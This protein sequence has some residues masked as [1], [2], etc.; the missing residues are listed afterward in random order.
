MLRRLIRRLRHSR[1]NRPDKPFQAASMEGSARRVEPLRLSDWTPKD[2]ELY[3]DWTP[4]FHPEILAWLSDEQLRLEPNVVGEDLYEIEI[5]SEQGCQRLLREV[6]AFEAW[7]GQYQVDVTQPNS[8][9]QYGV[10]LQHIQMD[11]AAQG[12]IEVL[13]PIWAKC[14]P[15]VGSGHLDGLHAF[16]VS[17]APFGGDR[18]LGFHV[19]NSEVTLNITLECAEEGSEIYFQGRRC[20]QHRQ[21]PHR[22]EEEIVLT[23]KRGSMLI[24]AGAH[25]HGVLPI[26]SGQRKSL[27][28]WLTSSEYR[29]KQQGACEPWC[30]DY[31]LG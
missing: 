11:K 10:I 4:L 24:H 21:G 5:F 13:H 17:Y 30:G 2:P 19:D 3:T 9:H 28:F 14:F 12:L 1:A 23:H 7:V 6:K 25:R 22:P 15:E 29:S 20:E 31:D 16:M 27:I 8:M 18:D 26:V